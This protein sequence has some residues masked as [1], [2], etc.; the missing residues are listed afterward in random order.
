MHAYLPPP[1]PFKGWG[2][3]NRTPTV[4]R[5]SWVT[6]PFIVAANN[7]SD[8]GMTD[9]LVEQMSFFKLTCLF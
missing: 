1:T 7:L 9:I 6:K 4:L 3:V 8:L 2:R 5:M